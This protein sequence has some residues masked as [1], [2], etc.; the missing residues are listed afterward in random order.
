MRCRRTFISLL[1]CQPS[2]LR[3]NLL[4]S[5]GSHPYLHPCCHLYCTCF[6][7]NCSRLGF[8][9][10]FHALPFLDIVRLFFFFLLQQTQ[11]SCSCRGP[12]QRSRRRCCSSRCSRPLSSQSCFVFLSNV[13]YDTLAQKI[14]YGVE[15]RR[16]Q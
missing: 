8:C 16:E 6:Q 14:R 10:R 7:I 1:S 5:I 12:S 9:V 3:W 2:N 11:F 13:F 15:A 4:S